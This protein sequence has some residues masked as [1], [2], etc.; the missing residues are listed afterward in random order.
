METEILLGQYLETKWKES[1]TLRKHLQVLIMGD[2]AGGMVTLFLGEW[3]Q[4]ASSL[5]C[6]IDTRDL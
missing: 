1:G 2:E 4:G 3:N 6:C 5:V